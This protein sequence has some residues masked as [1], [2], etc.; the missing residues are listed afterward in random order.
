MFVSALNKVESREDK[1]KT[2]AGFR[3]PAFAAGGGAFAASSRTFFIQSR[4]DP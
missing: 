1:R 2:R 4:R 3:L